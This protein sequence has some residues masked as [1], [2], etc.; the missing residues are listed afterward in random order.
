MRDALLLKNSRDLTITFSDE[1]DNFDY[2]K[3]F[4]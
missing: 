3:S 1:H 4:I 2:F